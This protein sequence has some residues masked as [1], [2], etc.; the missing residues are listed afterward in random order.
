MSLREEQRKI[1]EMVAQGTISPED[2]VRL[3]EA[4]QGTESGVATSQNKPRW[5]KIQVTDMETNRP[6]VHIVLPFSMVKAGLRMGQAF[7]VP[8][9]SPEIVQELEHALINESRGKIVD[10]VDQEDKERVEIYVE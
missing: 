2:G 3:L 5:L 7:G 8:G 4:L 6:R 9:L 1:L 10:V